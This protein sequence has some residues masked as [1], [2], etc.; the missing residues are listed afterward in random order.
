[1]DNQQFNQY[2]KNYRDAI[3]S[4]V[5][6]KTSTG[7]FNIRSINEE[8]ASLSRRWKSE[9]TAEGLWVKKL[10]EENPQKAED[11]LRLVSSFQL[12]EEPFEKPTMF[13]YYLIT[14]LL[15]VASIVIVVPLSFSMWKTILLPVLVAILAYGFLIP[16]GKGKVDQANKD[17]VNR[18]STQVDIL[19]QSINRVLSE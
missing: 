9:R 19:Y 12:K 10:S 5:I 4:L 16:L 15:T 3:V 7:S 11:F 8:V 18:Y 14:V 13:K 2:W 6:R 17:L 1:M